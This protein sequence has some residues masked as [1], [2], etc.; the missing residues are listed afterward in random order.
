M[1]T[2]LDNYYLSYS[3]VHCN[4]IINFIMVSCLKVSDNLIIFCIRL[5]SAGLDLNSLCCTH[6]FCSLTGL[7]VTTELDIYHLS[8]SIGILH[9]NIIID[10]G[11]SFEGV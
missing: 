8:H 7:S 3:I 10:D 4:I 2:E 5:K 9:C 6:I 11:F 1:I